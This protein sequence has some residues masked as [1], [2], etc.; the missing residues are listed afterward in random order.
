[1]V[2]AQTPDMTKPDAVKLTLSCRLREP[3]RIQGAGTLDVPSTCLHVGIANRTSKILKQSGIL[4]ETI[5]YDENGSKLCG[6]NSDWSSLGTWEDFHADNLLL[7]HRP[8]RMTLCCG[9][10]VEGVTTRPNVAEV[11]FT[12]ES[13]ADDIPAPTAKARAICR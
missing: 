2:F 10:Y 4:S 13:G 7:P 6:D 5:L 12:W 8:I 3:I 11:E 1:L 9:T